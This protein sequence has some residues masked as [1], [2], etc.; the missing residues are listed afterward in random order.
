MAGPAV[1]QEEPDG[2]AQ[3]HERGTSQIGQGDPVNLGYDR[4]RGDGQRRSFGN[5][6]QGG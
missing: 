5:G 1:Q 3:Q 2:E 6:G 4:R